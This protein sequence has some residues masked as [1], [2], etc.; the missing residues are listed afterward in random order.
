MYAV[1][2]TL[3]ET[4]IAPVVQV[5]QILEVNRTAFYAWRRST[6]TAGE[7]SEAA[8]APLVRII[9]KK[10]RRRY[11]ARRIARELRDRGHACSDKKV[12]R[13]M[14]TLGLRA[15]QP[16]S[17]VPK[18]T[19]SRHPLGYSPNLLLDRDPPTA[20]NQAWVGDLTYIPLT[21]GVFCYLAFLMDLFSR[22]VVGWSLRSDMTE[23]LV[24]SA[25]RNAISTRQPPVRL[26]H[27]TDRGG[28]YAGQA[29][30]SLLK[31]SGMRPSM[32]RAD[33]CYDNAFME[34]VIGTVKNELEI[35]EYKTMA[36]AREDLGPYFR[37]YNYER[38]HSALNY[39]TP[40]QF[41]QLTQ[42]PK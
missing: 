33:N 29:Y 9:F 12:S 20:A 39:R 25:L 7:E 10:H 27:H 13:V 40:A 31:R 32:S 19:A 2:E 15:I 1:V 38:K 35:T 34:S 14:K 18:T 5:C 17:F 42:P 37:Y 11:G 16:R 36:A 28:Q 23:L 21:G 41:E 26:I 4:H 3:V 6:P 30:R 24:L 8:L 22:R